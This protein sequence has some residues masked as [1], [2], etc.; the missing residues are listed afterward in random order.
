MFGR[1]V[2]NPFPNKSAYFCSEFILLMLRAIGVQEAFK[3]D[4]ETTSPEDLIELLDK[5]SIAKRIV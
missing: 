4:Q 1:K 2:K 3:M 5:L